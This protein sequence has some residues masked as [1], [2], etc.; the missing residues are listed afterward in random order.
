MQRDALKALQDIR[1]KGA[2]KSI[3]IS[4]TG[5]GKTML[6]ALDVRSVDPDRLLFIVQRE[7]IIDRTILEYERVLGGPAATTGS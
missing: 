5:T 1:A 7:Q 3:I 4:A 6:S 2:K